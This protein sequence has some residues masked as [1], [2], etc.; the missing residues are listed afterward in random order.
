MPRYDNM[1]DMFKHNKLENESILKQ[2]SSAY[3][4]TSF[5]KNCFLKFS[6][7]DYDIYLINNQDVDDTTYNDY[8]KAILKLGEKMMKFL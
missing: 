3:R 1:Q 7:I 6:Q 4:I 5:N 8:M 2:Y